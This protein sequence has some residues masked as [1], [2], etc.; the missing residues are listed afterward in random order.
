MKYVNTKKYFG[1]LLGGALVFSACK[2][3]DSPDPMG[4]AG[5]TLVKIIGGDATATPGVKAYAID[6]VNK[7]TTLLAADI[8]RDVPNNAELNKT[9]HVVVNNDNAAVAAVDPSLI[10]MPAAWYTVGSQTPYAGGSYAVTMAPGEFAKEITITIPN[11]TVLDP[12]STYALGFTIATVDA[13]GKISEQQTK[14]V[15]IGA[16]NNYDGVYEDTWTNYHPSSNPG[17]TGDVTEIH[18]VTTGANSCKMFWP[19]GGG[20]GNPSILGGSLSWFGAQEPEYTVN[21]ATY[22]VTVQNAYVGAT[23]FYQMGAGYDSH[24][25]V[26]TKTFYVRFGY[27]YT[28]GPGI[29]DPAATREW[30]QRLKYTGPR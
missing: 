17:Y 24:Y 12:S 7:P 18:L 2:K 30:T 15:T 4:D 26:P 9:M 1:L 27:N 11:A 16:K 6:F 19:L 22:K 25:D 21:P 3:I 8:R 13:S 28:A 29:F 10:I 20:F 23:T 14:V 5:Q